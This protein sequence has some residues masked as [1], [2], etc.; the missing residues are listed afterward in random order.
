MVK[1]ALEGRMPEKFKPLNVITAA[2]PATKIDILLETNWENAVWF[3]APVQNGAAGAKI[4]TG[5]AG[6]RVQ[7]GLIMQPKLVAF[8]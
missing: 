1:A 3:I 7:V 4:H 5:H 2:C 8:G 6:A